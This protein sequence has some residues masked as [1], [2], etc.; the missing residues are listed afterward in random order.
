MIFNRPVC[1]DHS[2]QAPSAPGEMQEEPPWVKSLKS[3]YRW[4][5]IP[6]VRIIMTWPLACLNF[7]GAQLYTVC[8]TPCMQC[9]PLE[10]ELNT[11][12]YGKE[13]DDR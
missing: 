5:I 8:C 3:I 12:V 9:T 11:P 4:N 6:F 1:A 13:S 7:G 10:V 2:G